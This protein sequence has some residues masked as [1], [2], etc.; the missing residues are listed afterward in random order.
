MGGGGTST[1]FGTGSAWTERGDPTA[2]IAKAMGR[3]LPIACSYQLE[4]HS[5]TAI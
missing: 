2:C 1:R 5:V 4:V 3:E